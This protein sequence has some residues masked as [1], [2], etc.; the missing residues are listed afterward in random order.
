MKT[1]RF[2]PEAPTEKEDKD[3]DIEWPIWPFDYDLPT[4]LENEL[5]EY[6]KYLEDY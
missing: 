4:D 1:K 2:K 6:H 3:S 5:E